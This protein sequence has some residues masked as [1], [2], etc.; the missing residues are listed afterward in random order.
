MCVSF[1]VHVGFESSSCSLIAG[2][3]NMTGITYE[4]AHDVVE[5]VFT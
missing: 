4:G 5:T 2:T 1:L 3:R